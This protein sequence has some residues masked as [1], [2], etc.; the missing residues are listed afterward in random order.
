M[1]IISALSDDLLLRILSFVPTKDVM[2][3][4]LLSKKWRFLWT[5]VSRLDYYHYNDSVVDTG[6][7]K[8]FSQF[9]YRSLLSN[10]APVLDKLS[11][12]LCADCPFIDVELWIS[13]ALSHRVRELQIDVVSKEGYLSLPSSL[14][15]SETLEILSLSNSVVLNVPLSVCLPSLKALSLDRVDYTDNVTLPRLLSGSPNL[16]VLFMRRHHGDATTDVIVIAPSLKS[17]TML[18]ID[19]EAC[20][21]FVV[22]TPSLKHLEIGDFAVYSFRQMENM[23]ALEKAGVYMR[24]SVVTQKFLKALT[25]VHRLSLYLSLSELVNL[26]LYTFHEGWWDLLTCMLQDSPNL[27]FLRLLKLITDSKSKETPVGWR[28]PS[29]VPECLLCSLEAFVWNRYNGG[30][31]DREMAKYLLNN[32][33]C[34]KTARFS[35]AS[36]DLEE[37]YQM[38]KVLSS[39]PTTS[40]SCQLLFD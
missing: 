33:A 5:S 39:V 28:P 6:D 14:Y 16:E 13:I 38:L 7:Y 34:L 40:A 29:S 4:C 18:D 37:K 19:S 3:T 10:K 32:A 17:L 31:G 23:P 24:S 22:D 36:T 11:L 25:S 30:Q 27:R 1:D 26:D 20:G 35:P 2:A 15:T 21:R 12:K 8:N 9:V